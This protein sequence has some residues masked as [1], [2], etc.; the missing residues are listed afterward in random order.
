[1]QVRRLTALA[2]IPVLVAGGVAACSGNSGSGDD[3]DPAKRILKIGIGEPKHIFPANAGESEGGQ[4]VYS[5]FAGLLDYDKDNKPYNVIA[6]SITTT[7]STVWTIKLKDGFTFHNGEKVTSESFIDAWNWGAY[8]PNASDVNPYYA[9]IKG[10]TEINPGKNAAAPTTKKLSG[11]A[12]IDD[13]TFTVTLASPFADFSTELGYTAF[14]PMP[15]A[16]FDS[17]GNVTKAYEDAPIGNGPYKVKGQWNH[18]QSI[19]TTRF[20]GWKG[21]KAKAAGLTFKI[22][23]DQAAQYADTL[24][25]TLDADKSIDSTNL[26]NAKNDFGSRYKSSPSSYVGYMAFPLYDANY[27]NPDVRKA[28]SMAIDRD[29][30]V[31]TVFY[32]AYQVAHSFISPAIPGYRKDTCGEACTFNAAAAKAL[33]KSANGPSALQISYNNDGGHKEWIEAVCNQLKNT[34]GVTCEAKPEAKFPD[35]LQKLKEKTPGIGMFR[36]AWSM[37]Y[38]S[39][40]DY[41]QPLFATES[42]PDPNHNSYSNPAFDTLLK[43]GTAATN[44]ADAIKIWQQAEDLLVKDLPRAPLWYRPNNYVT[45]KKVKTVDVNLFGWVNPYTIEAA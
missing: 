19:E 10:Y 33:Y 9:Q 3:S 42:I 32:G 45:S 31:K 29:Q 6:D 18:N 17:S 4:V 16:A 36:S 1:M 7:D 28:I 27:A 43:Q 41:L 38:P 37:D 44:Q 30:I 35:L 15:K 20:D 21:N 23:L 25:G 12:K 5:L 39:M 22:Y 40:Y 34:L 13:L 26:G 11:L 2:V 8:G 24:A 14:Y